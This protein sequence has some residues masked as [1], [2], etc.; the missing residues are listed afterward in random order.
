MEQTYLDDFG[1]EEKILDG[2]DKTELRGTCKQLQPLNPELDSDSNRTEN[3]RVHTQYQFFGDGYLPCGNTVEKLPAGFY[4][5]ALTGRNEFYFQPEKM[6]TDD[7]IRFPGSVIENIF[8]DIQSFWDKEELFKQYNF[9]HRR[10]ILLYGSAGSGKTCLVTLLIKDLI[11]KGGI[12]LDGTS[13][14]PTHLQFMVKVLKEIEPTKQVII[15]L[16]DIDAYIQNCGEAELLSFLDGE[17]SKSNILIIATTNYPERLDKR[18]VARPRRFDRVLKIDMPDDDVRKVY[19]NTK[20]QLQAD[21]LD[22]YVKAT[23][24]FS[25]AAMAE[26]VISIKCFDKPFDEAVDTL[27]KILITKKSSDEYDATTVGFNKKC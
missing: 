11:F 14:S 20:L 21:E 8:Q 4:R 3:S 27:R 2:L 13:V 25:F 5:V 15:L 9:I 24:D 17:Y 22:K 16:E 10:G 26:L 18:I 1:D 7:L 23:K 6:Q 19:F 12:V